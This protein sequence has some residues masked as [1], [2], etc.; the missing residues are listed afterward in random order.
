MA[1]CCITCCATS[2]RPRKRFTIANRPPARPPAPGYSLARRL[3]YC[4]P[5]F[6]ETMATRIIAFV[7]LGLFLAFVAVMA[8]VTFFVRDPLPIVGPNQQLVLETNKITTAPA[9]R[10][11][12]RWRIQGAFDGHTAGRGRPP[13]PTL[14]RQRRYPAGA[15][16]RGCRSTIHPHRA[17]GTCAGVGRRGRSAGL[18]ATGLGRFAFFRF[19]GRYRQ[20]FFAFQPPHS[21]STARSAASWNGSRTTSAPEANNSS[22]SRA[23]MRCDRNAPRKARHPGQLYQRAAC[24]FMAKPGR[25]DRHGRDDPFWHGARAVPPRIRGR[26]HRRIRFPAPSYANA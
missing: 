23:I 17:L 1:A 6:G 3:G 7:F 16:G 11:R 15:T 2:P 26:W 14:Y 4:A 8:S 12:G 25:V 24:I 20:A 18:R 13:A 5:N 9:R 10:N 21:N 19:D 22:V